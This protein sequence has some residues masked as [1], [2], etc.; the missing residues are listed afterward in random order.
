MNKRK[1]SLPTRLINILVSP[2]YWSGRV[3]GNGVKRSAIYNKL[4]HKVGGN[5]K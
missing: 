3:L 4:F 2:K 1:K 5:K